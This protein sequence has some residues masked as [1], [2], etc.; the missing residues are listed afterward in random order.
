MLSVDRSGSRLQHSVQRRALGEGKQS[1]HVEVVL[2]SQRGICRRLKE[3]ACLGRGHSDTTTPVVKDH[4]T[5]LA[6]STAAEGQGV[7]KPPSPPST[8]STSREGPQ[9]RLILP[10]STSAQRPSLVLQLFKL[11][12]DGGPSFHVAQK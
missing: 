9:G 8:T 2:P 1:S 5:A 6:T 3:E 11:A 10:Q 4:T 12:V 7:R